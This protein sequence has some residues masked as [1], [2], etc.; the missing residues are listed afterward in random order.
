MAYMDLLSLKV[1]EFYFNQGYV[2]QY[3][4]KCLLSFVRDRVAHFPQHL[5]GW[6]P[7]FPIFF[8]T[9]WVTQ[10]VSGWLST[11]GLGSS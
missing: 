1:D 7:T 3:R 6:F 4:D 8:P 11:A 9:I 2:P 5:R 10:L